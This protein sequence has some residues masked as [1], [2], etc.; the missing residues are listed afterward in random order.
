MDVNDLLCHGLHVNT[1][2]LLIRVKRE[3]IGAVEDFS[4]ECWL[5][6]FNSLKRAF[7]E[8]LSFGCASQS[9]GAKD[10]EGDSCLTKWIR[11]GPFSRTPKKG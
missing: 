10:F 11:V 6:S 9:R 7:S 3:P 4:L 1:S 2:V 5:E 8:L